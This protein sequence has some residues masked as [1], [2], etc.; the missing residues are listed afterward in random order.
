[1]EEEKVDDELVIEV[2]P[3]KLSRLRKAK[4]YSKSDV[5]EL[6]G[7]EFWTSSGSYKNWRIPSHIK[8]ISVTEEN[9]NRKIKVLDYEEGKIMDSRIVEEKYKNPTYWNRKITKFDKVT[10]MPIEVDESAGEN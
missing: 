5:K 4:Y 2:M 9:G 3:M 8:I 6:I 10:G 1:M 7:T